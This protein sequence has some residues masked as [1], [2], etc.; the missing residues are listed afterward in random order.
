MKRSLLTFV[1]S[2]ALAACAVDPTVDEGAE[3]GPAQSE[4]ENT[5]QTQS[6]LRMALDDSKYCLPGEE[7][8]CTLGPPPVC[9]CVS[10]TP[11][12]LLAR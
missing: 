6:E 3:R 8:R 9:K 10:K 1:V 2:L 12:I 5:A 11:P 4:T 7:V